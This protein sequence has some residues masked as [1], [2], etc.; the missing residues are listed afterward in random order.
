MKSKRYIVSFYLKNLKK[1]IEIEFNKAHTFND[2]KKNLEDK[3]NPFLD[4]GEINIKKEEIQYFTLKE[5]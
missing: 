5:I 2:I 3:N 4:L 1:P